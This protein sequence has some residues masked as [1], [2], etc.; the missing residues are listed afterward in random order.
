MITVASRIAA[1]ARTGDFVCRYGGDEFLVILPR[2]EDA[3]AVARVADSI[4][5]R[6]AVPYRIDGV[7]VRVTAAVGTAIY[8]DEARTPEALLRLADDSMY[9]AK[10][11]AM[12]MLTSAEAPMR[13][14]DDKA[15]RRA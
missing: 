11:E 6:I 8:L 2:L 10:A 7:E 15:K 1:R 9:R 12:P 3:S 5:K 14:R 13:R 4:R